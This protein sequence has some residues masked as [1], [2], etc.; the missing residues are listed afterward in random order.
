MIRGTTKESKQ[1]LWTVKMTKSALPS[2]E[3]GLKTAVLSVP[4]KLQGTISRARMRVFRSGQS[5]FR[6]EFDVESDS[7]TL[8]VSIS[9]EG[10]VPL[11]LNI[12][13]IKG[14]IIPVLHRLG[15]P[16]IGQFNL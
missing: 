4:L 5:R 12:S 8:R 2:T 16:V 11:I 9:P 14:K 3:K 13:R 1:T 7:D 15:E 10:A 6:P